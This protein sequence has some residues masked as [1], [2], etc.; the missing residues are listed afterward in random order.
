MISHNETGLR[1]VHEGPAIEEQWY[2]DVEKLRG[3][4]SCMEIREIKRSLDGEAWGSMEIGIQDGGTVARLQ[5]RYDMCCG[6]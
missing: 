3:P 1:R 5:D 2:C 4:V 6:G